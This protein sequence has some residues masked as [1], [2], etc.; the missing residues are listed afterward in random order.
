M[1]IVEKNGGRP[2]LSYQSF[3]KLVGEPT[4][5]CTPLST[6]V[7]FLPPVGDTG[8]SE[9][10]R[11]PTIED[12]GYEDM[13]KVRSFVYFSSTLLSVTCGMRMLYAG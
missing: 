3:L 2:P 12:L 9:I 10:A 5:A 4:W 13:E 1:I 8:G 6:T 11:V 7:S